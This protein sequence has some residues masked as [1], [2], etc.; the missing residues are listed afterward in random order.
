LN[1]GRY[2]VFFRKTEKRKGPN[3]QVDLFAPGTT[4]RANAKVIE[5]GKAARIKGVEFV[6][7]HTALK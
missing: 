6:I 5:L 1:P 2:L 3:L 7:P 4:N